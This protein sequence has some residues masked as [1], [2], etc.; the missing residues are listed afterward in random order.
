LRV[1]EN[2]TYESGKTRERMAAAEDYVVWD[3]NLPG[4]GIRVKPSAIKS[5]VVQYRNRKT[6]ESRRKT[7]G[8]HGPLLTFHQ[9]RARARII[10]ADALK[11]NDPVADDRAVR[12]APTMAQLASDYLEQHAIPKKRPRSV[13]NDRSM[14]DRIILPKLGS[15]KV[16]AIQ[17]RDIHLLHAAMRDTPYQAN[18]VLALLSKMLSLAA[19][20]GWR[21][22]NPVKGIERFQEKPRDRWLS[23]DELRR[24]LAVLNNHPN[25]RAANAVRFQLLT[26]ARLGEVR[27][28]RWSDIDMGRGVWTKPT[29]HTK[30]KRTEHI[31]LSG[32]TLALLAEMRAN[33]EQ[34]EQ[35]LFP[36][37]VPG[38][39]LQDIK[40]F[41]RGVLAEAGIAGYRLHDNRHT[42]ASHLVSSGL[43][44]EIVGRLLG[45]TNPAT[46]KRYAHIADSPLRAA[47]ERFG[48][49]L[50]AL[51]K[52]HKAEIIPLKLPR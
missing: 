39:P 42:H 43:S 2:V 32:P 49:K 8:Q 31:P 36:G 45:H 12:E 38:Q 52:D 37:N 25:Q 7:I 1:R 35:N 48:A 24:L 30:Q 51:H 28:A 46:T 41:W 5:Y 20:W 13:E 26:G 14:I 34:D 29:H 18:R 44:L 47:T 33:V 40:K 10:L 6:G 15:K 27:T 22:D 21:N 23:D 17:S 9:A 3:A 50:D 11:G 19:K 4:F 16:A